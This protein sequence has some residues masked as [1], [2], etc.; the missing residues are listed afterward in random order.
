[1]ISIII[2]VHNTSEHI[3]ECVL[4]LMNGNSTEYEILLIENGS[5]DDSF[6]KCLELEN[7]FDSV[8]VYRNNTAGVSSARNLGLRKAKGDIIGFCDADDYYV[9]G[10]LDFVD[11]CFISEANLDVLVTGFFIRTMDGSVQEKKY[12]VEKYVTATDLIK[13]V[14]NEP[15]IM[16]S[17]C[18]KFYSKKILKDCFFS[19]DLS[20]CE[21]THF[22]VQLLSINKSAR[23]KIVPVLTYNYIK[24]PLSATANIDKSFDEND[25]LKYIVSFHYILKEC[26]LEK[27]LLSE[28][29]YAI[30][31]IGINTLHNYSLDTIKKNKI[32]FEIRNNFFSFVIKMWSYNPNQNIKKICWLIIELLKRG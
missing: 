2:P 23:C 7:E 15:K 25:N 12:D 17:V 19:E 32:L 3:R 11:S 27:E 20:Y 26:N 29:K 21:D 6:F 4:S 31:V 24:H 22:N 16:G 28:I 10:S 30:V 1:M 14:M 5:S 13:L 9:S 8:K 18:N